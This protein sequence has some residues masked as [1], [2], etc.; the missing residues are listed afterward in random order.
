MQHSYGAG[1]SAGFDPGNMTPATGAIGGVDG[2]SIHGQMQDYVAQALADKLGMNK[3]NIET[4]LDNG[5]TMYQL[6]IDIGSKEF[7][8]LPS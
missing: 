3:T 6:A 8:G 1:L 2:R 5:K 7:Y 4:A